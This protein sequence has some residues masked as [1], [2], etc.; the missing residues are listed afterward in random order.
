MSTQALYKVLS[1]GDLHAVFQPV[2]DFR[3][4][5]YLAYEALI[6]GPV[7][8]PLHMPAAL[9]ATAAEAGCGA[10]LERQA[11][12]VALDAFVRLKS[13]ALLF[14]NVSAGCLAEVADQEGEFRRRLESLG[15]PASRVVIEITENQAVEDFAAMSK[16][17]QSLRDQGH[18]IA[19]DDLGEGFSNLRMWSE[20]RPEFVKVDRHF[21]NGIG[22]DRLKFHLVRSMHELS[23]S[24]GCLIVAEGI[25]TEIEFATVRNLKIACGQGYLI[26]PPSASPSTTPIESVRGLLGAERIVVYPWQGLASEGTARVGNLRQYV[27]PVGPDCDND[28]VYQ[29]F[30]DDPSL[31]LLPVVAHGVP[32]GIVTRHNLIDRFA[33][34]YRREL[35]GRR[36][37]EFMMERALVVDAA[38]AIQEVARQV[39]DA[40]PDVIAH[41]FVIVAGESYAGIGLSRDL[42][43][44]ITEMQLRAARYAN[45]LT[46]L[47]GNVPLNE[48]MDRL[49]DAGRDFVACYADLNH[50]KPYNDLYGYR[51]GDQ[52]IQF[53]GTLLTKWTIAERDFVGHVGGDDFILLLQCDDW[54]QRLDGILE[55][56]DAATAGFV[57]AQH[58]AGGGYLSEDRR[59]LQVFH[60]LPS[61]AI[62]VLPVAAGGYRCHQEVSAGLAEAKKQAKRLAGNALFVERRGMT[63]GS[64][65]S[66]AAD[67]AA[68]LQPA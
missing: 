20:V 33:R 9:F 28:A 1:Q 50:F 57:S 62:G 13:E 34:P 59:G 43:K 18:R 51:R 49:L 27:A 12:L 14:L 64:V 11:R 23:E 21:I 36:A 65:P 17:L 55:E 8:S 66:H 53:L 46:M 58:F 41:G 56:F 31:M 54:E 26:E 16:I 15:L 40:P 47:P 61:L 32:L 52:I 30:S 7:G 25:E 19:I 37:C 38:T 6:R 44:M 29:R 22:S 24:A 68:A 35:F 63:A 10:E 3:A 48:H 45:P 60:P 5:R 2:L 42:M 39:S 67:R 4:G